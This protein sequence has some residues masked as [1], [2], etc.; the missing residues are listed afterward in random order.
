MS[1][2]PSDASDGVE[3]RDDVD[4]EPTDDGLSR[5]VRT[6]KDSR[7]RNGA[8]WR[9]DPGMRDSDVALRTAH[10]DMTTG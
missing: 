7:G 3:K 2:R 9:S 1:F 6:R 5:L 10:L 8:E 4:G